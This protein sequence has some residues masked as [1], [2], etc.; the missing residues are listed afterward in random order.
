VKFKEINIES[1]KI[2]PFVMLNK[3]WGL[4][5]AGNAERYNTMTIA[6]GSMGV[7][8]NKP[9]FV[10]VVRPQRFTKEFV[11]SNEMFTMSFFPSSCN[12]ALQILGTKSG[13]DC[14]KVLESGLT[15]L[16]LDSAVAFEE[17]HTIFVCK[18]LHGGQQLNPVNFTDKSIDA[19]IYPDK[20]YHY[21]YTG[22]IVKVLQA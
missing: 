1:L 13:R 21:Y 7:M 6:W 20:D 10:V 3:E 4:L 5:S 9:T 22:E 11:D 8:W 19:K 15:P 2:N 14:D 12:N 16:F 18:K 17:A